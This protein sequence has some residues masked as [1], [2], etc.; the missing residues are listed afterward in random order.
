MYIIIRNKHIVRKSIRT[1]IHKIT[2]QIF[3]LNS[4]SLL[5][6]TLTILYIAI[7]FQEGMRCPICKHNL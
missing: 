3:I 5:R 6:N 7:I 2:E 4:F 1:Y